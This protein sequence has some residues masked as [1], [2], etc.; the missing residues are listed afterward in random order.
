MK[1]G[2]KLKF[3][4]NE[5]TRFRVICVNEVGCPFT[6]LVSKDGNRDG[7]VVK[8]AVMEHKCFRQFEV[9]SGSHIF[10]LNILRI[11]FIKIPST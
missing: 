7:L 3:E 2:L 11:R 10:K 4:K 1:F 6:L 5:P 8:T 9:P